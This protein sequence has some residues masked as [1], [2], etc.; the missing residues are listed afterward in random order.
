LAFNDAGYL[1]SRQKENDV[2]EREPAPQQ[3][4]HVFG[5]AEQQSYE[6]IVSMRSVTFT[7][8]VCHR[9]TTQ[10]RYPGPPPRYC[11][12]DCRAIQAD[13]LKRE[14]VRKQ[15]EKRQAGRAPREQAD[16]VTQSDAPASIPAFP[17]LASRLS[18]PRL[19][20]LLIERSRLLALL[21]VGQRQKLTLLHAPAGFGKT[22]LVN[23]WIAHRQAQVANTTSST[24]TSPSF[25]P[26]AWISLEG[27]DNDPV[28]FWSSV[29]IA[30]QTFQE[31]IGLTALK[32]LS[33]PP[34]LSLAPAPLETALAYLF[35]DFERLAQQG[36]VLVLEDYHLIEHPRIHETMTFFI[37]H[38]PVCLQVI[39]LTRSEPP[40]PLVRWRARGDL[41]E[42][43]STQLRF[44]PEETLTFLRQFV[45]HTLSEG[46]ICSLHTHLEGWAAGLRL[47]AL[48]LQG[49]MTSQVVEDYLARLD[50]ASVVS[51]RPIQEYFMSEVLRMQPD[52]LQLFLLQTSVLSRLTG[53]LCDAVTGRQDSAEWLAMVERSGF[54]LE[55]LDSAGMWYRYHALF[56]ETMRVEAVRRLG[57]E[58]VRHLSVLAS[59]WYEE[60]DML[61]D[62]IEAA[63]SAGECERAANL[64]E[65][66]NETTYFSEYHTL[67]R[68]L[69]QLPET[70]LRAHP[71]LCFCY[72]QVRQAIEE[73]RDV[74]RLNIAQI[75]TLLQMAEEGWY[76]Q[77]NLPN[78]GILYA[79]RATFVLLQGRYVQAASYARQA[80]QLP[81]LEETQSTDHGQRRP[82]E[83]T[84]WRCGC[85]IAL[86]LESMGAG[87]FERA[88]QL[89][90][91]AYT[92][93][94]KNAD[95]IF[96][97]IIR[98]MLGE[99]SM[100]MGALH[101]ASAYYQQTISEIAA[102][103][104]R[105]E[106]IVHTL[107]IYGMARLAYERNELERVVGLT[108]EV[109]NYQYNGYLQH[110]EEEIQTQTEILRINLLDIRGDVVSVQ[111]Q[112]SA[113]LARLQ[114]SMV[115]NTRSRYLIS[116]VLACQIRL[117]ILDGDLPA[118]ERTLDLLANSEQELLA[119]QLQTLQ[120]LR[121]RL[122]LAQGEVEVAIFLLEQT[123]L[124]ALEGKRI[125]F[126]LK[127]QV[128][129]VIAYAAN[130]QEERARQQLTEV[131]SLARQEG[132]LRLFLDEGEPLAALL[133]ALLS[134]V[135]E[136]PL[137]MYGETILY[138][139][140]NPHSATGNRSEHPFIDPLT[141]QEQRVLALLV[142]GCSNS[143][144][145][146]ELIVS[147]NTV[148]GHVKNLYRKL[149]VASR[150]QAGELARRYQLL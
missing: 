148:K 17:L 1:S 46:A 64:I 80:L 39:M 137:R 97:L 7:C 18:P 104:G 42:V 147:V 130:K 67:L 120:L 29:I 121:A 60:H 48:S 84:D 92:L 27:G 96:A 14:R 113:L 146:Q 103:G 86:G 81:S 8:T 90:L 118:A 10:L 38:L 49:E 56:A 3:I 66:L 89:F 139:F 13:I 132:Y 26:V 135:K 75:E 9:Q 124:T 58:H 127:V 122:S 52:P 115:P 74:S 87:H 94:L 144:I 24:F 95:H 141:P 25:S 110:W 32:Q 63:F 119:P 77:G 117:Q 100:E 99:T 50:S 31:Q 136:K 73:N 125:F 22:T 44:S 102:L 61:V 40:L 83:W 116:D 19:P 6:R 4:I 108:D 51:H 145:A 79:F 101:Q 33:Q 23:Q 78:V 53:S 123:L 93:S 54:F 98:R 71:A 36:G 112:L 85:L 69:E 30:C 142:A 133:R 20:S 57:D 107:S 70:L 41:L 91:E 68:W 62:A 149:N 43:H 45:P 138:A 21:D 88:H 105:G 15:R 72:A 16:Y 134:S 129:L 37:E 128:L 5:Q 131:L 140:A 28:R 111:P 11:S 150:V 47:L 65:A 34:Q 35:N 82:V 55:V 2:P 114:A 12:E 109:A 126:S 106:D 76:Q 143:E 59:R